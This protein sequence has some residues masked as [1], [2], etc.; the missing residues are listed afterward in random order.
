MPGAN[1]WEIGE[2]LIAKELGINPN[3]LDPA[4]SRAP[5]RPVEMEIYGKDGGKN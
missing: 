4:T 5:M 3:L 2:K 1:L